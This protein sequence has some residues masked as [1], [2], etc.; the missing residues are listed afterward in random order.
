MTHPK[1]DAIHDLLRQGLSNAAIGKQLH[2]ERQTVGRIR[3]ELGIP[4]LPAQPLT[5]EEKWRQRVREADGGHL[6]WT[7][8]RS[9]SGNVPV[10]RHSGSTYT[11]ARLGFRIQ[12]GHDP[13]GYAKPRCGVQHCV[14]P[15]HQD[16]TGANRPARQH[17]ARYASPEAKLAALTE[18]VDGGHVRWTGPMDGPHPLLKHDGR[19]WPVST[20]AFRQRYGREPIGTVRVGCDFPGC[21]AGAHLDDTPA[22]AA[23]RAA[24]AA[25][26]L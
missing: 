20:L 5:V 2:V 9:T 23:H 25:L 13:A 21:L 11:A 14:A 8:E 24:Y 15:S 19:R 18:P 4:L 1:L 12:H 16:D 22:R 17:H 26:G 6:E 10:M 3:H 7:G